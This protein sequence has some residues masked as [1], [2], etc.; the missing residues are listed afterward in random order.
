MTLDSNAVVV[1]MTAMATGHTTWLAVLRHKDKRKAAQQRQNVEK[2][3]QTNDIEDRVF[4][5][6][7]SELDRMDG[8]LAECRENHEECEVKFAASNQRIYA[9]EQDLHNMKLGRPAG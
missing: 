2:I 9:L 1:A 7:K 5:R 8:A 6:L 4:N 3:Q